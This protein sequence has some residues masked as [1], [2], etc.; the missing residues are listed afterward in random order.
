MGKTEYKILIKGKC[1]PSISFSYLIELLFCVMIYKDIKEFWSKSSP[2][3]SYPVLVPNVSTIL[4]GVDEIIKCIY[5][6]G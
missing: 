2:Q 4:K 5:I 1:L 3:T 6:H